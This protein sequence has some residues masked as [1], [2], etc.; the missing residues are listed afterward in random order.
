MSGG[1]GLKVSTFL[2][3]WALVCTG[4]VVLEEILVSV[5]ADHVRR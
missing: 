1:L 2:F 5:D 4:L 3:L